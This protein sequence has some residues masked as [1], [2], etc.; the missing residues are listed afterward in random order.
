MLLGHGFFSVT[1]TF[2]F[3]RGWAASYGLGEVLKVQMRVDLRRGDARMAEQLL[4]RT[5]VSR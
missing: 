3:A 2:L 5:Q 1:V 4:Y